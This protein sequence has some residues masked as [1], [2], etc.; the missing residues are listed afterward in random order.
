MPATFPDWLEP[1]LIDHL[2]ARPQA[3]LLLAEPA[4]GSQRIGVR[5]DNGEAVVV[6]RRPDRSGRTLG[7]VEAQ[8]Y[9]SEHGF[10]CA[11]PLTPSRVFDGV[12]THAEEWRPD[13]LPLSGGEASIAERFAQVLAGLGSLLTRVRARPLPNPIWVDWASDS[14][15][16]QAPGPVRQI[17][18]RASTRLASADLPLVLGHAD[19]TSGNILWRGTRPWAVHNWDA[20]SFLPEAALVGA[21]ADGYA[22]SGLAPLS[23]AQ[24]FIDAYQASRRRVFDADELR[25]AW[26]AGLWVAAHRAR[27]D[28]GRAA[29][30]AQA[31]ARLELAGA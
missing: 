19:W 7:C 25:V 31:D 16:G 6:K 24:R 23:S 15:A 17:A 1:W 29:L 12:A 14:S 5:L 28:S 22:D 10:P 26:A 30:V 13:G 21:A 4:P 18:E 8:R 9:C 2:H 20:L 3:L 11:K 27:D